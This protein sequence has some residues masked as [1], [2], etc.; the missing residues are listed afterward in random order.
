M[1]RMVKHWSAIILALVLCAP[2]WAQV[3]LDR[4]QTN[5]AGLLSGQKQPYQLTPIELEEVRLLNAKLRARPQM[6]RDTKAKCTARN[7]ESASPSLLEEAVL[8]LKCSQRPD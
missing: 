1:R 2:C 6:E 5:Y 4:A 3:D 8:D 7:R